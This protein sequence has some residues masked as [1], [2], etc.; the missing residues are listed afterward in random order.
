MSGGEGERAGSL[1]QLLSLL[2]TSVLDWSLSFRHHLA[3][4]V[5]MGNRAA[6][7]HGT[8]F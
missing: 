7:I 2:C 1:G 4:L 5:D 8:F 6:S 3:L